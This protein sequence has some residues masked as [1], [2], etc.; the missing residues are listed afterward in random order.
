MARANVGIA[1]DLA[2]T[3]LLATTAKVAMAPAMNPAMWAHAATKHN[4]GSLRQRGV[5][6][7]GPVSGDTACGEE[8]EGRMCEPADIAAAAMQLITPQNKTNAKDHAKSPLAG[9]RIIVT[10]GPTIEPIDK[11]RFI[12]NRSSGKQGHAIAATL[13]SRGADVILISGPV[14]EPTP[15]QVTMVQ[16]TTANEMLAAC[17]AALPAEIAICAA[18]VADWRVQSISDQKLKKPEDPDAGMTLALCQN[19][20]ILA[21]ISSA[22][23]RPKLVIGFAAE[24]ENLLQNA[25]KKRRRK[26][27]DWIIA[28]QVSGDADTVFGSTLNQAMLISANGFD[29]WPQMQKTDLAETLADHIEAEVTR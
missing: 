11:V 23:N 13:A 2:T 18:A 19:P 4:F 3:I 17:K 7:I 12:A 16:V 21:H 29:E 22:P 8:G 15:D 26:G 25:T 24:T 14:N 28:N 6:M 10:S 1:D 5:H 20:D 27:C 9:K